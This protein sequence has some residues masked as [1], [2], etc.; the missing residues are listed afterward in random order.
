MLFRSTLLNDIYFNLRQD[1]NMQP[2]NYLLR[3][4]NPEMI[5]AGV[6][7]DDGI[8]VPN[9]NQK[10]STRLWLIDGTTVSLEL[11]VD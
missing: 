5:I 10:A 1:L 3:I 8:I 6:Y 9:T 4:S 7:N 2:K 11:Y